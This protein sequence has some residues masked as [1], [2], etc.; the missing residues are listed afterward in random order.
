MKSLYDILGIKKNAS[1]DEI[2][3]AYRGKSMILHPDR[4]GS[5]KQFSELEEA[6]RIL[7]D[8]DSRAQYD[9]SGSV[10]KG[11][12]P[13][14]QQA[15]ALLG[16]LFLGI[17]SGAISQGIDM[18]QLDAITSIKQSLGKII[19]N[20]EKEKKT[21]RNII[22]KTQ[23]ALSRV[24]IKSDDTENALAGVLEAK[25]NQ[26]EERFMALEYDI[27]LHEEALEQLNNYDYRFDSPE[28]ANLNFPSATA[29]NYYGT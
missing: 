1:K 5:D 18:S 21:G 4:G 23:E 24:V 20:M 10:E 9:S 26:N 3:D 13:I 25:I 17:I 12:P 7:S 6:N 29:S 8:D 28:Q 2:K 16:S 27:E 11:P 15:R 19:K 14:D 22:E